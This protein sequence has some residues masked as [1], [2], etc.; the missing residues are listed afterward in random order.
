MGFWTISIV[1][2]LLV[3]C[4]RWCSEKFSVSPL[5]YRSKVLGLPGKGFS[6]LFE[7]QAF[8]DCF[9]FPLNEFD[10][11]LFGKMSVMENAQ[12]VTSQVVSSL[13]DSSAKLEEIL[14]SSR[15]A[16]VTREL[17]PNKEKLY[18][19][20]GATRLL[21]RFNLV[22]R[23]V[24]HVTEKV[25]RM[26]PVAN[27]KP[28]YHTLNFCT[29]EERALMIKEGLLFSNID[30][31][32]VVVSPHVARGV[33]LSVCAVLVDAR[34]NK[35]EDAV[36]GGIVGQLG[37]GTSRVLVMP[38]LQ[39]RLTDEHF[40]NALQL[41]TAISRNDMI[42]GAEMATTHANILVEYAPHPLRRHVVKEW[43]TIADKFG[44]HQII[45]NGA[46]ME[47]L[48]PEEWSKPTFAL[49]YKDLNAQNGGAGKLTRS[50]SQRGWDFV[51][52]T[53][54]VIRVSGGNVSRRRHRALPPPKLDVE[55]PTTHE[56]DGSCMINGCA[57]RPTVVGHG[58]GSER[59]GGD[60]YEV[61]DNGLL[62]AR[63]H[64]TKSV[65][66]RE[67]PL[68]YSGE[69]IET[70]DQGVEDSHVAYCEVTD[71]MLG[72][73]AVLKG[74]VIC[75][76]SSAIRNE[77]LTVVLNHAVPGIFPASPNTAWNSLT[78]CM[79]M[80]ALTF[81][82]FVS[83][84]LPVSCGGLFWCAWDERSVWTNTQ[85]HTI[86]GLLTLPGVWF[87]PA[88]R[89]EVSLIVK[90]LL[91]GEAAPLKGDPTVINMGNFIVLC[92]TKV[93]GVGNGSMT[94]NTRYRVEDFDGGVR[95]IV[96]QGPP[97]EPSLT[98]SE[99]QCNHVLGTITMD[100]TQVV[101][102]KWRI[103]V[104]PGVDVYTPSTQTQQATVGSSFFKHFTTWGG[105]ME[106][107]IV[108]SAGPQNGGR[109]L[110]GF[111]PGGWDGVTVPSSNEIAQLPHGYLN[112]RGSCVSRMRF[113]TNAWLRGHPTKPFKRTFQN[114]DVDRVVPLL[115]VSVLE[116][117]F[118]MDQNDQCNLVFVLR[119]IRNVEL[120]GSLAM[121]EFRVIGQDGF[122]ESIPREPSTAGWFRGAYTFFR[123]FSNWAKDDTWLHFKAGLSGL[124][125]NC[126][127]R[128]IAERHVYWSG[129]M[130]FRIVFN[131]NG[132]GMRKSCKLTCAHDQSYT[133]E[134]LK[135]PESGFE[136]W[137]GYDPIGAGR[138]AS[139]I[140]LGTSQDLD[141]VVPWSGVTYRNR[142]VP[143]G[144]GGIHDV[145]ST[146]GRVF[147]EL[148]PLDVA[149]RVT[150][151][152]RLG[153]D[154]V[155]EGPTAP[156]PTFTGA[157]R[158]YDCIKRFSA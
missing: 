112:M 11:I 19:T 10:I 42:T 39:L 35:M 65:Y 27:N 121:D 146:E 20:S 72:Y 104:M 84:Q 28:S 18:V 153:D 29:E 139:M 8:I 109:V 23:K 102:T 58:I 127:L 54:D 9:L 117:P 2:L 101:D 152:L 52:S 45:E 89:S 113:Q 151:W 111:S 63:R 77:D 67:T 141:I 34:H 128:Y 75:T 57:V 16:L 51:S 50:K 155:F 32:E 26:S 99:I 87:N 60:D 134:N 6:V 82:V 48:F 5:Y 143:A 62:Y 137:T 55:S 43:D 157:I 96:G 86:A 158:V 71:P 73:Q 107:E 90:P 126:A 105:E 70:G 145:I 142:V 46:P 100:A 116:P 56:C 76:M 103:A 98:G 94:M 38:R 119:K 17:L 132:P 149:S 92:H 78:K 47:P 91:Y 59:L 7:D 85:N 40:M 125:E 44:S 88:A 115:W 129:S 130:H 133:M 154:F 118:L 97:R 15:S 95:G 21:Q 140:E 14:K 108:S 74:A 120:Y 64:N 66:E 37:A 30:A 110:V 79:S 122:S 131:K 41:V 156:R 123:S 13:G 136:K 83:L 106:L 68:A 36:L 53:S 93:R 33:D 1:L 61:G 80:G 138:R 69:R 31:V 147:V 3:I 150:V 144:T 114:V 49:E 135:D 24:L 124:A 148:P 4:W 25:T 22:P 12:A 81:R